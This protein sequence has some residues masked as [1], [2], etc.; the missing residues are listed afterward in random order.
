MSTEPK[1]AAIYAR[2]SSERQAEKD[3]SI[4]AQIKALKKFALERNWDI[5]VEYVDQAESARTANRPAFR[6]MIAT[7]K[8][9]EK[10]FDTIL[11]WKLSRFARN[12]EDSILYK[13]LLRKRGISVISINEQV[14]KSP[15]GHLLEGI[16]EVIDEFYSINLSQDTVRGMKENISRGFYNGGFTPLGYKRVKIKVG[17][18]EKTKLAVEESEGQIV[19]KIFRMAMEGKGGKE[20]AKALNADGLRTKLGKLF[21]TTSINHILRNEVYTGALIWRPRSKNFVTSSNGESTEVIR[22]PDCHAALVSKDDFDQ[23][24]QFLKNR[25]P[26]AQ[27]PRTV[28]SQ[29]LLSGL[30]HCGKCGYAMSGCW[31][32]SGQYFYYECGQHQKKGKEVCNSRLISKDRLESFV[33]ERIRENILTDE[34]IEQL[35]QLVN[36]ELIED[37]GLYE[38]QINEIEQ[39]LGQAQGRLSKLYAALETGKVDIEDLAPRIK[40]L[41]IQQ[42]ELEERRNELL[43]KMNDETPRVL[44]L[45]TIKEYVSS[46]KELLG[47]SSFMEQKSFLRSFVKRVELNEPRVVI[48]YA[49]PLPINGL[50][51]IEEVLCIGRIGSRGRT[52]T[53]DQAVNS[54][55]L[56]H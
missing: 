5:V 34:N 24:Q 1:R 11:V 35:V 17:M 51:T 37:A 56:Y 42:K 46:L 19:Q 18:A 7:A 9:N 40:E 32:K 30:L 48:D 4:P 27:H 45:E 52:R 54:R 29:Y 14:D 36:D 47:S 2:V 38:Q 23:V 21:S 22:I 3:L 10:S 26:T 15:A 12:R 6:E 43:D 28:S 55:P 44:S 33:L 49:M 41:R 39:Q 13:S 20:I 53:Y 8:K 50:T 16:I 31:A 25:R